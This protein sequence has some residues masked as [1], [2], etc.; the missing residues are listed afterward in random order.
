MFFAVGSCSALSALYIIHPDPFHPGPARPQM[1]R[2]FYGHKQA[3]DRY[4]EALGVVPSSE[5]EQMLELAPE[6]N[7]LRV[8]AVWKRGDY[9]MFYFRPYWPDDAFEVMVF[10]TSGEPNGVP[11]LLGGFPRRYTFQVQHVEGNWYFWS[12]N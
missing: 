1:L 10:D 5:G 11:R 6:L 4:V 9:I 2:T 3:F 8:M 12:F 7:R